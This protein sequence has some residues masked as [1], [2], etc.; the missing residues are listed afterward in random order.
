MHR[1]PCHVIADHLTLASV[2]AGANLD[3]EGSGGGDYRLRAF[4]RPRR[5]F[6]RGEEAV[7]GRLDLTSPAA[8][9]LVTN[10][11]V[12]PLEQLAPAPVPQTRELLG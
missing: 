2:K 6:E 9:E 11:G 4:D 12:V 7:P 8:L 3:P 1:H 5:T 10:K